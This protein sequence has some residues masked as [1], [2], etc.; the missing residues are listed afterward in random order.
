ML[1]KRTILFLTDTYN[2]KV[3]ENIKEKFVGN[4]EVVCVIITK[5]ELESNL[6][7]FLTGKLLPTGSG[8]CAEALTRRLR[9]KNFRMDKVVKRSFLNQHSVIKK[10]IYNALNRYNPSVVAVTEQSL[11]IPLFHALDRYS[12]EVKVAVVSDEYVLDKRF[13]NSGVDAYFVD[14]FDMRSVLVDNDIPDE[15]VSICGL[16]VGEKIYT[17]TDRESA[18]TKFALNKDRPTFLISGSKAG[19]NRFRK[20]LEDIKTASFSANFIVACGRNRKL[21]NYAR[22]MGFSAY[23]D[24][25]DMNAALNACDGVITRPTT[26][27][28]AEAIAKNKDVF[29]MMPIGK[30]EKKTLDYLSLDS[31]V[32]VKSSEALVKKISDFIDMYYEIKGEEND[33]FLLPEEKKMGVR[34]VDIISNDLVAMTTIKTEE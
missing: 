31:I 27:L 3:A 19:D 16:A 24:G 26:M 23:N 4:N 12:G 14:N 18:I 8:I 15:K 21:L 34:S 33:D 9:M 20:V 17:D 22:S 7:K 32:K 28:V 6:Y 5:R 11:I 10:C 13:I 1:N 29:A 25:I 2:T 30:M